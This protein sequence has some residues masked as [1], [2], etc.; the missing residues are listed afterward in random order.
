[1]SEQLTLSAAIREGSKLRPQGFDDF[2]AMQA[3]QLCSCALGAAYEAATGLTPHMDSNA[4]LEEVFPVL[5]EGTCCP[6]QDCDDWCV[7]LLC[8]VAH[9]NDD[10]EWTRKQI[11]DWVEGQGY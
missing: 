11:A 7:T 2:F 1:M 10:H 3:G 4:L 6:V 5:T 8:T 9:L